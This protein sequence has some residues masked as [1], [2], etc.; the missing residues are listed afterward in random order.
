MTVT[1]RHGRLS[2][3]RTQLTAHTADHARSSP[4]SPFTRN[5]AS[6]VARG[7]SSSPYTLLVIHATHLQVDRACSSPRTP[8][9]TARRARG[10]CSSRIPTADRRLRTYRA[11][12]RRAHRLEL[13]LTVTAHAARR[14]CHPLRTLHPPPTAH[15]A[16]RARSSLRTPLTTHAA[17]PRTQ[18]ATHAVHR[19][20]LA[21][22]AA[23]SA[24]P[25]KQLTMLRSLRM[26]LAAHAAHQARRPP[27]NAHAT[28]CTHRT[29]L[30]ATCSTRSQRTS[31]A[32]HAAHHAYRLLHTPLIVDAARCTRRSPRMQRT[33]HAAAQVALSNGATP[34]HTPV[35]PQ[36]TAHA[37]RS[38]RRLP[39]I[40]H[41]AGHAHLARHP[42]LAS[43]R[44]CS[45]PLTTRCSRRSPPSSTR[46][47]P[48]MMQPTTHAALR[49][50]WSSRTQLATHT[51]RRLPRTQLAARH[52]HNS[53]LTFAAHVA[54][55]ALRT[56]ASHHACSLPCTPLAV[57]PTVHLLRHTLTMHV[58]FLN[59]L[60]LSYPK[61]RTSERDTAHPKNVPSFFLAI[62][63]SRA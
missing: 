21:T 63:V 45:S 16:R 9:T 1:G 4:R 62:G 29:S 57:P 30:A 61:L 52:V 54:R 59:F 33:P 40:A 22:P 25:S 18:L 39:L 56:H 13:R 8:P 58:L 36:L 20:P 19:T 44:T 23:H 5:A 34:S 3:S 49:T 46:C 17:S 2:E 27:L 28:H 7:R 53:Q 24:R 48:Y 50:R 32:A 60:C 14:A 26:Q 31:L 47:S 15:A 43:H 42:Q 51:A 12:T 10:A 6:G 38:A 11:Y 35:T 55:L 41:A 37:T